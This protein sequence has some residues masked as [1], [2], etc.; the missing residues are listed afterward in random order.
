M[1][2]LSLR[3]RYHNIIRRDTAIRPWTPSPVSGT[4]QARG[5]ERMPA[6]GN[7]QCS[8]RH[9]LGGRCLELA[10]LTR[11]WRP[12]NSDVEYHIQLCQDHGDYWDT[13]NTTTDR[14]RR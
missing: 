12:A 13:N 7:G 4:D 9:R 14:E 3:D 1:I 2:G 8:H 5:T 10:I 6:L 11:V